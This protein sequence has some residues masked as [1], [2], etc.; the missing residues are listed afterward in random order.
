VRQLLA[1]AAVLALSLSAGPAFAFRNLAGCDIVAF[2][3]A[4]SPVAI[5]AERWQTYRERAVSILAEAP[6]AGAPIAEWRALGN[7]LVVEQKRLLEPDEA[8]DSYRDYLAGD[9]CRL[10]AKLNS[11]SVESLLGEV[12]R[13]APE[14]EA[15]ALRRVTQ[16]ARSQVEN[17]ER[18]ARFRS[19]LDRTLFAADYYCF[20]AG[21]I[22]AL[23]PPETQ[24]T[25]A[26]DRFGTTIS[27]RDVDR[28]G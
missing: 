26:L 13:S 1:A 7:E 10:L 21:A 27:C 14:P 25:I 19:N 5:A 22:V 8:S 23:L 12:E 4:G 16:A 15:T 3:G 17:I 6:D 24:Q 28:A 18:A 9:G 2:A 20:V 11:G